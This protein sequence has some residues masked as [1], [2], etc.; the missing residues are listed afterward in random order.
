M[1]FMHAFGMQPAALLGG[2]RGGDEA[3]RIGVVVEPVEMRSPSR[4]GSRRR[5][6]RPIRFSWAKLV[7][8]RMPGTIGTAMPAA[9]G[10]V[11]EA[12]E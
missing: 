8:G 3:A 5:T 4:P 7:T 6:L 2:E 10:A 1:E 11:A 12:Q 9:R